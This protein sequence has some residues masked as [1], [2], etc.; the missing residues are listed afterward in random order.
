MTRYFYDTE[1]HEDGRTIDLLSIGIVDE[2]G[3]EFYA[4]NADAQW[5]RVVDHEWLMAN[6][7]P[8]FVED[9]VLLREP[10]DAAR[11]PAINHS[12]PAVNSK[13]GIRSEV[14]QFFVNG[15]DEH[16]IELCGWFTAYDHVALAQL[17]GSMMAMPRFMPFWT[18]DL[19]Q[20]QRRLERAYDLS[21][22]LPAQPADQHHALADA[23]WNRQAHRFLAEIE[24]ER[25]AA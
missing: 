3:R 11:L 22:T 18:N 6:V 25:R 2:N 20:E 12:H 17:W 1:F 23:R 9:G 21:I 8:K 7:V 15:V 4:V 19:C 24:K 5:W 10:Y 13:I 14:E 16:G